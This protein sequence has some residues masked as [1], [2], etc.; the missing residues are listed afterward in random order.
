[1]LTIT[2]IF[3]FQDSER[4]VAKISAECPEAE[5]NLIE[6]S[7][8]IERLPERRQQTST[9]GFRLWAERMAQATN[10]DLVLQEEGEYDVWAL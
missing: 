3:T 8:A 4:A 5:D 7:G 6:Y 1:M 9:V 2:C 10:A